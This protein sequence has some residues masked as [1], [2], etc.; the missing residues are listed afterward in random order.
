MPA[1]NLKNSTL[2]RALSDAVA[3]VADLFQKEMR[4]ARAEV[5]DKVST[6][7]RA[8]AWMAAAGGLGLIAVLLVVQALV[9]G[10]ASFGIALHWSCLIVAALFAVGAAG[11]FLWGRAASQDPLA[12]TRTIAQIKRDIATTKEQLT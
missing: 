3:D 8:G 12:P 5:V 4:L 9:F 6:R 1:D 2:T 11:T 10:V 7:L